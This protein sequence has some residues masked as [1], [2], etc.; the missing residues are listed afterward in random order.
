MKTAVTIEVMQAKKE[1]E[2]GSSLPRLSSA[3]SGPGSEKPRRGRVE[4]LK[5]W[6]PDQTGNPA[7]KNG[8]SE[9]NDLAA[10]I[11]RAIFEQDG[12]AIF[13]SFRKLL[14]SG[15]PYGLQV[16]A[17]RAFGELKETV[18]HERSPLADVPTEELNKQ[19]EAL[20]AKCIAS[21]RQEGYVITPPPRL[22]PPAD[23]DS[24]TK[25]N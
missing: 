7:G 17:D 2:K 21:L 20:Q 12:E 23:D 5:P 24:K 1:A 8:W 14:R 16:L 3:T 11:A 18:R 4:N 15:S 6:R 22:L 13:E 9:R 10:E 19:I 25:P